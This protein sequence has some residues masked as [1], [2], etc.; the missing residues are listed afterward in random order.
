MN[1]DTNGDWFW[2]LPLL[3]RDE[4]VGWERVSWYAGIARRVQFPELAN[5]VGLAR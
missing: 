1:I 2:L 3:R 4:G 5:A